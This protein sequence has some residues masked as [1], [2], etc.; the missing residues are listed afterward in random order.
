MLPGCVS[1][2]AALVITAEPK[3]VL[4]HAFT[5]GGVEMAATVD[6]ANAE[7]GSG[8]EVVEGWIRQG[9]EY[10]GEP[11]EDI[12]RGSSIPQFG[13]ARVGIEAGSTVA[14]KAAIWHDVVSSLAFF[15]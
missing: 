6:M 12:G 10:V 13:T 11:S 8:F 3:E 2:R 4:Q 5:H 14:A 7:N 1:A 15:V 9:G